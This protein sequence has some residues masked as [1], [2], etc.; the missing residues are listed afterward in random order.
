MGLCFYVFGPVLASFFQRAMGGFFD[1][2]DPTHGFCSYS[3]Q[4]GAL[5]LTPWFCTC[6][7]TPSNCPVDAV[8][9][10]ASLLFYLCFSGSPL[11]LC[12][13]WR[14]WLFFIAVGSSFNHGF[15]YF[16]ML[17]LK[18]LIAWIVTWLA[19]SFVFTAAFCSS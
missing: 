1:Y 3:K 19:T 8:D 17:Q 11:W 7:S 15:P 5:F 14:E 10:L 12:Y 13:L 18:S 4:W 9:F 16:S 6:M 2:L